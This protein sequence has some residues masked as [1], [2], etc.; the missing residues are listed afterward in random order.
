MK[1]RLISLVLVLC[2][3]VTLIPSTV[4]AEKTNWKEIYFDFL[5]DE[6]ITKADS[7]NLSD[8]RY[9]ALAD[10]NIDG[11]PELILYNKALQSGYII[12]IFQI[13]D[14]KLQ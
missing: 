13:I 5:K 14:G 2:M 10:L 3:V 9:A 1:K 8:W 6:L 11:T 12:N 7:Y 4:L